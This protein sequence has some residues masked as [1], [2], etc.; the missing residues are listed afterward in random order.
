MDDNDRN[1]RDR[2]NTKT[3]VGIRKI[4]CAKT[5]EKNKISTRNLGCFCEPCLK[6]TDHPC[7]NSAYVEGWVTQDLEGVG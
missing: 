2:T 5:V 7:E 1:R 4:Q 3:L 6:D